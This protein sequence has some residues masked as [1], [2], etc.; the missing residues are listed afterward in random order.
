M[1]QHRIRGRF[2]MLA[3]AV[4]AV[5]FLFPGV[6]YAAVGGT[7]TGT[8]VDGAAGIEGITVVP[9]SMVD[10]RWFEHWDGLEV[11]TA[12]DGTYL[13]T[14]PIGEYRFRFVDTQGLVTATLGETYYAYEYYP[15]ANWADAGTTLVVEPD[16]SYSLGD[17][18][19][20]EG[21]TISGAVFTE[22]GGDPLANIHAVAHVQFGGGFPGVTESVTTTTG[23]YTIV[24]LPPGTY[25][26]RFE[27]QSYA[28]ASEYFND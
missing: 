5:A 19:L 6:A 23:A 20:N 14:L 18:V 7:V 27:D 24:G 26:V 3:I 25:A 11:V 28:H 22:A 9:I 13:L 8:V 4:L 21:A 10:G 1:S 16:G 17:T 2:G 15:D 12:A